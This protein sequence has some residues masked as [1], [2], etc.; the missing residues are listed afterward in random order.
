MFAPA[1]ASVGSGLYFVG[2]RHGAVGVASDVFAAAELVPECG[3]TSLE[4][5]FWSAEWAGPVAFP[6]GYLQ[7]DP[8]RWA[9]AC[10]PRA[11]LRRA[12]CPA[13]SRNFHVIRG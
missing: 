3:P 5:W 13:F 6:L 11:R 2:A 10:V 9:V 7:R 1:A 4:S 8:K 12:P